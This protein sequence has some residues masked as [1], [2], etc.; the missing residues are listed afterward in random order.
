MLHASDLFESA[1][2]P[3]EL[4]ARAELAIDL[5]GGETALSVVDLLQKPGTGG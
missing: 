2:A 1:M 4:A 3:L 5:V